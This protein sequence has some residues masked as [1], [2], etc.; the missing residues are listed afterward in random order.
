MLEQKKYEEIVAEGQV[1][2]IKVAHELIE[3]ILANRIKL[4]SGQNAEVFFSNDLVK[5]DFCVKRLKETPDRRHYQSIHR[6]MKMQE[7]VRR[8]GV[9]VPQPVLALTTEDEES[10]MVMETIKGKSLQDIM[11]QKIALPSSYND[12]KFWDSLKAMM[13]KMHENNLYHRDFHPGNI[14]LDFNTGEPVIIDFGWS[15]YVPGGDDPY[16]EIDHN[17]N[18]QEDFPNDDVQL[19]NCQRRWQDYLTISNK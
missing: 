17:I 4:G 5:Q 7:E 18:H 13:G 8:V 19:K 11:E 3:E 6:E 2:K 15:A 9:K 14:M 12:K 16:R 1:E 10:F